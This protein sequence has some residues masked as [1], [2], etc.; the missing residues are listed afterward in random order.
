VTRYFHYQA[1]NLDDLDDNKKKINRFIYV[2]NS[3]SLV[4]ILALVTSLGFVW[5]DIFDKKSGFPS[6]KI[7]FMYESSF[8]WSFSLIFFRILQFLKLIFDIVM[9]SIF[10]Y[11]VVYFAQLDEFK[12]QKARLNAVGKRR[13]KR[14]TLITWTFIGFYIFRI[15]LMD[16]GYQILVAIQF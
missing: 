8:K 5:F 12:M 2:T 10:I 6:L 13:L 3:L 14:E 11:L 7:P 1:R 15:A 9:I 16:I 4:L